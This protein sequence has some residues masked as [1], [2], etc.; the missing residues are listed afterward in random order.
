VTTEGVVESRALW[1]LHHQSEVKRCELQSELSID[2]VFLSSCVPAERELVAFHVLNTTSAAVDPVMMRS[3]KRWAM[4]HPDAMTEAGHAYAVR[5][6]NQFLVLYG[7]QLPQRVDHEDAPGVAM[8][9]VPHPRCWEADISNPTL[10]FSEDHMSVTRPGSMSCYPAA[11]A[12]LPGPEAVM[13]IKL[14]NATQSSNWYCI[15]T[16]LLFLPSYF[17]DAGLRLD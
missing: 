3:I 15:H 17:S 2:E 1:T 7:A 14:I 6:A 12:V 9:A 10:V 11:F 13:S 5:A 8:S 4:R 16:D